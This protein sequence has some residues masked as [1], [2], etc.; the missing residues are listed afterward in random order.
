MQPE[1]LNNL[2]SRAARRLAEAGVDTPLL[3]AR[4]LLQAVTGWSREEMILDP[5]R[6][7]GDGQTRQF[8]ALIARRVM[9]EP[10]AR[11][12]GE[13]E[14]YGRSFRVTPDTLDPRPDTETLVGAA[15]H[16]MP[17]RA[18][19]LDLGTG[20][21]AVIITL[22][23][24]RPDATGLGTDISA[25]ALA[26]ATANAERHALADRLQLVQGSWFSP[27]RGRFDT[28]L[29]NPPYIPSADIAGLS[30]DV[31]RFDPLAALDG[32]ADGLEAYRRIADAAKAHLA[33]E[34]HVLVEIGLGQGPDVSAVFV[35]AGFAA[36][37]ERSDLGGRLRCLMFR[38]EK[39]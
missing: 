2:V 34:G 29:S 22:L 10:V 5:S 18:R 27:V 14:F 12:L 1:D 19:L 26:V 36:A 11:I 39:K 37:G 21:G 28:I 9:R 24:E 35:A 23:A 20:T 7:I 8:D 16:L 17:P 4:L 31:R 13:R 3:D 6:P 38:E 33:P 30:P 15:L 25:A 32:G